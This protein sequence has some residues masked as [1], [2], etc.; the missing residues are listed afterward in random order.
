M[1][2]R[3]AKELASKWVSEVGSATPGFVGAYFAGSATWLSDDVELPPTSDVDV[4]LVLEDVDIVTKIGKTSYEGILLDVAFAPKELLLSPEAVL[5][6][7]H[8]AGGFRAPNIITDPTGALSRLQQ[9]VAAGFAKRPWVEKRVDHAQR[10][11]LNYARSVRAGDV[12]EDQAM[13]WLFANGVATHVLLAAGL[14]NPTVR[15][16]YVLARELLVECGRVDFYERLLETLGCADMTVAQVE[17]HLNTLANTYD[18]TA[19]AITSTAPFARDLTPAARPISIDGSRALID[20]GLHREAMFWIAVT[21]AR[22]MKALTADAPEFVGRYEPG[23]RAV[24]ADLGVHG[25]NDLVS[26]AK[27]VEAFLPEARR[28]ADDIIGAN[29]RVT[30]T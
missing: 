27:E 7:Y 18:A 24:L 4:W 9:A 20:K 17:K 13:G 11:S 26:R 10:H 12:L 29:H 1:R 22:C 14:R 21:N 30:G 25:E 28:V 16:R 3:R 5:A 6:D 2:I 15:R 23:F 8:I 19:S